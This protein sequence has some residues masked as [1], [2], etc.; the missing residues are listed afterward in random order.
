MY[1]CSCKAKMKTVC[2]QHSKQKGK[3]KKGGAYLPGAVLSN[4]LITISFCYI[5]ATSWNTEIQHPEHAIR[6]HKKKK[7]KKE[8]SPPE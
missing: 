7:K 4:T 3:E 1:L 2:P 8:T 5:N 6:L